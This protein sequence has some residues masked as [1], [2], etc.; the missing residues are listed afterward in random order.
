MHLQ[1]YR[2]DEYYCEERNRFSEL[3]ASLG[4]DAAGDGAVI[5]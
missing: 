5:A 1:L 4:D 3:Y 2:N